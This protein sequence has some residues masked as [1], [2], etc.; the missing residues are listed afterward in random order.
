MLGSGKGIGSEG[1]AKTNTENTTATTITAIEIFLSMKIQVLQ[2]ILITFKNSI[3]RI[4]GS[5]SFLD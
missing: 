2:F 1:E 3:K 5:C 4:Y